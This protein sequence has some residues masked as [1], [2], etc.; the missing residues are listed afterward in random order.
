MTEELDRLLTSYERGTLTRR[1][2]LHAIAA[3]AV[4]PI[5]AAAQQTGPGVIKGY[6]LHHVNVRVSDVARSEA[7]YRKVFG[8]PATR[9]IQGVDAHALD[10]PAGGFISIQKADNAGRLDHFCVGVENFNSSRMSAAVKAAGIDGVREDGTG[11]SF[12][13]TDPDGVRVQVSSRDWKG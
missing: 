11:N 2:L 3:V 9:V 1:Q 10:V 4:V 8:F 12:F 5:S 13:F 6:N 7:F